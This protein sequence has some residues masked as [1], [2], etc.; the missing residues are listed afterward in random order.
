MVKLLSPLVFHNFL[1]VLLLL[2]LRARLLQLLCHIAAHMHHIVDEHA[3]EKENVYPSHL[4][5]NLRV[6]HEV[7]ED[8][9]EVRIKE[10]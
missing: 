5:A 3:G 1:A 2:S 6:G 7:T 4:V 10:D 9:K 8:D